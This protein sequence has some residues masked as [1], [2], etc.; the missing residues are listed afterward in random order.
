MPTWTRRRWIAAG[1]AAASMG[2]DEPKSDLDAVR[3]RAQAAGLGPLRSPAPTMRYQAIGDAPIAFQRSALGL[4]EALAKDYLAHFKAK[5][6]AVE[7]PKSRLTVVS[8]ADSRAY[9]AFLGVEVEARVGGSYDLE[10]NR[11][12]IFDNRAGDRPDAER[13]N[14]IAL[15]HEATHQ[16][17]FNTGLLDRAAEIPLCISEGLATYGEVRRPGGKAKVG[18][19]NSERWQ[20]LRNDKVGLWPCS[21]LIEDDSLLSGDRA[22]EAYAQSWLLVHILMKTADFPAKFRSYLQM[23]AKSRSPATRLKDAVDRLGDTK[24]LD[25]ECARSLLTLGPR[26]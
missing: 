24:E 21:K 4:C 1:L 14:T 8:L 19:T 6:F 12:V 5:G 9:A 7:P 17:T 11:L 18:D 10:S 3:D 26:R 13:S 23:L 15:M 20:V 2:A 16:L 22:Q 25:A